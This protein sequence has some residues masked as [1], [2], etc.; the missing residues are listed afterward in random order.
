MTITTATP[1]YIQLPGNGVATTFAFPF[2]VFQATDVVVGFITGAGYA[3]QSSGYSVTNVGNNGGGNVVFSTPPPFLSTVDIRSF[4]PQTQG[5]EFA[6]LGS[7]LP[8]N[9]TTAMDRV[10]RVVQDLSR[11]TY[12][13][14]IHGPDTESTPWPALPSAA[15]RLGMQLVFDQ[16]SGLPTVGVSTT[17]SVTGALVA[18]LLNPITNVAPTADRVISAT[19]IA[20]NVAPVNYAYLPGSVLR[21]GADPTGVADSSAAFANAIACNAEVFDDYPGG[22]AYLISVTTAIKSV[23]RLHGQQKNVGGSA[24][25]GTTIIIGS[26]LGFNNPCFHAATFISDFEA[27]HL[28]FIW[29]DTS[30][31]QIPFLCDIDVRSSRFH[32]MTFIGAAA[33]GTNMTCI[34]LAGGGTFSGDVTID[35]NYADNVQTFAYLGSTCSTVRVL[36]NELYCNPA[37]PNSYGVNNQSNVGGVVV[38]GNTFEAWVKGVYAPNGNTRL[39]KNYFEGSTTFD[40]DFGTSGG[41]SAIEDFCTGAPLANFVFT[42]ASRNLIWS[43]SYGYFADSSTLNTFRGFIEQNRAFANGH[44]ITR[45]FAA[46]NYQASG[47]MSW[48]VTSGEVGADMLVVNGNEATYYFEITNS[49]VGGSPATA[50][51]INLATFG[52]TPSNDSFEACSITDNG[53]TPAMGMARAIANSQTLQI[54]KDATF[55]TNWSTSTAS[56]TVRGHIK[57]PIAFAVN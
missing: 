49:A 30:L 20:N 1:T 54:Y 25:S 6:N 7:Y 56:T 28:S 22:G 12:T 26:A 23:L 17:Q 37:I 27:D 53:G 9:S 18:G 8:E 11:L 13:F 14:G 52:F 47:S 2:K 32:D 45:A 39:L 34:K 36:N 3:L 41:N 55:A 16:V 21:Y 15:S 42:N 4:T 46:G 31:G 40:F 29:Q 35:K 24:T 5:T 50:L 10:T 38:E 48:T 51:L 43:G 19:E 33:I 44:Q 57:F